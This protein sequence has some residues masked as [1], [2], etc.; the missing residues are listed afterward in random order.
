MF[1]TQVIFESSIDNEDKLND[2]MKRKLEELSNADG[3]VSAEK[4]KVSN[5]QNAGYA[6][7]SKWSE[8]EKFQNWLL[9]EEHVK[10]HQN[11]DSKKSVVIKKSVYRFESD[12]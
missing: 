5:L 11:H 7:V 9:R 10:S 12:E 3:L 2:I 6:L 8:R 1:I 4:W